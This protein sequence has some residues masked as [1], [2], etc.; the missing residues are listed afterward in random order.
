MGWEA[1]TIGH[2]IPAPIPASIRCTIWR[3][4][5]ARFIACPSSMTRSLLSFV[6]TISSQ[7]L[8]VADQLAAN[9][10]AV[11][12]TLTSRLTSA[13]SMR[14]NSWHG[15]YKDKRIRLAH[16]FRSRAR[17]FRHDGGRQRSSGSLGRGGVGRAAEDFVRRDFGALVPGRELVARARL[18]P[19]RPRSCHA[20]PLDCA[21]GIHA[22]LTH[23]VRGL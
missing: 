10:A 19:G 16:R 21:L 22:R 12:V 11:M 5:S 9:S 13:M 4:V 6:T 14:D 15:G 2:A 8:M 7:N 17:P 20:G 23:A 1:A 18:R 3:R